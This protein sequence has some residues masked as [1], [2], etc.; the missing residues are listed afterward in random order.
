MSDAQ[1]VEFQLLVADAE[2]PEDE[3][4]AV[5]QVVAAELEREGAEVSAIANPRS[6]DAG[7]ITKG[8]GSGGSILK[9][10]INLENMVVFG[11]WLRRKIAGTPIKADFEFEGQK[12]K[13][14]GQDE[15]QL[16]AAMAR[17]EQFV[18]TID[19]T[20]RS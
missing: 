20:K 5:L 8:G 13:F 11:K 19:A 17:F 4:R 14:E 18:A 3:L 10:E 7:R 12:F 1:T 2:A 6:G 15:Q 9:A 16:D